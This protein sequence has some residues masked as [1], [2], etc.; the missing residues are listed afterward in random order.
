MWETYVQEN[1]KIPI[2]KR[3]LPMIAGTKRSSGIG[4]LLF[5]FIRLFVQG[6]KAITKS[7]P[8]IIPTT[9]PIYGSAAAPSP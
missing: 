9:N 5:A 7:P 3:M 8:K 6:W 2:G 4:M 1:Q